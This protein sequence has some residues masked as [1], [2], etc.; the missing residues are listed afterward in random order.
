MLWFGNS[1]IIEILKPFLNM[2]SERLLSWVYSILEFPTPVLVWGRCLSSC[3]RPIREQQAHEEGISLIISRGNKVRCPIRS[4]HL[5]SVKLLRDFHSYI[6]RRAGP[7]V[8]YDVTSSH[9]LW[10]T[11]F[12]AWNLQNKADIWNLKHHYF[13]SEA[14]YQCLWIF[15]C[16]FHLR[17]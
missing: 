15:N 17:K 4:Q 14:V 5:T 2:I 9:C 7:R 8:D 16:Q 11:D 1:M 3:R 6:Y 10:N 13:L 12:M